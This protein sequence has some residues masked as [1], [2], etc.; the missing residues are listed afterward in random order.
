VDKEPKATRSGNAY[1]HGM[2]AVTVGSLAY[3]ATQVRLA[4]DHVFLSRYVRS[5]SI[6]IKL[7][8][9]VFTYRHGHGL[10]KLLSQHS[11]FIGRP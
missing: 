7:V 2:K 11:G 1:L 3:V 9:R 5:D 8:V 10:R 4:F 6:F